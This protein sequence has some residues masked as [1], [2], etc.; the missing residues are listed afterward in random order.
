MNI[1]KFLKQKNE[2]VSK[3]HCSGWSAT[4]DKAG[5][6]KNPAAFYVFEPLISGHKGV[7]IFSLDDLKML[8]SVK[9]I[10]KKDL[11]D[12][13]LSF[14]HIN[15]QFF[16]GLG[17]VDSPSD[18]FL[19]MLIESH[20]F[21][22]AATETAKQALKKNCVA[23]G[24]IIYINKNLP[25]NRRIIVR[26]VAFGGQGPLITPAQ[27]QANMLAYLEFDYQSNPESFTGHDYESVVGR[28]LI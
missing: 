6:V 26:P 7:G 23:F 17:R 24:A 11:R 15:Q 3:A 28:Y 16:D 20:I 9:D 10:S 18:S 2:A 21:N 22:Y 19:P 4:L 8:T 14:A 13:D 12:F 1:S 5:N 27:V 25:P